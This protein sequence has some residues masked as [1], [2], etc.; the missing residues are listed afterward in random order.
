[1]LFR[2]IAI[3]TILSLCLLGVPIIITSCL[4]SK[5]KMK[6]NLN[7]WENNDYSELPYGS[8]L[9]KLLPTFEDYNKKYS[10]ANFYYHEGSVSFNYAEAAY[11]LE[12]DFSETEYALSK[13]KAISNY[14][15]LEEIPVNDDKLSISAFKICNYE[16]NLLDMSD[17]KF[18]HEIG[19]VA[20]ENSKNR[21]RY[22]YIVS[23]SLDYFD[24]GA[25]FKD[26]ITNNLDINW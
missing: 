13:E 4:F 12:L 8:R 6:N 5:P 21:I 14:N 11:C 20:F 10:V 15:F 9:S 17:T 18:P 24:G 1:M 26:W 22:C 23:M 7:Y 25:D 3:T 16:I 19:L 2:S